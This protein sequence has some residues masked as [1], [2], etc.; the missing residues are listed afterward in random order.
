VSE[1]TLLRVG[2]ALT[3][4]GE[5]PIEDAGILIDGD[6]IASIGPF[7]EVRRAY[8][9]VSDRDARGLVAIPGLIDAHSHGRAIPLAEQGVREGPLEL[10]LAQLTALTPLDPHD[11]AFVAGSDLVAAG[12]TAVQVFFHTIDQDAEAYRRSASAVAE[13][14]AASGIEFELVLGFTD[15]DEFLPASVTD[16]PPGAETLA[17]PQRGL[18]AGEF[19]ALYDAFDRSVTL[20]PVAP[21]WCS[22]RA[23]AGIASRARA[24][25]RVHT[26]LLESRAQR[27][28]GPVERLREYGVLGDR[29]SAAHAVWLSQDEIAECAAAGTVL[30]HCPGSNRKL[31]G[32][33]APVGQWL[34]AGATAALG[35]DSHPCAD[36]PDAFDELRL[37]REMAG[38]RLGVQDAFALATVGGAAALGRPELGRLALGAAASLVLVSVPDAGADAL[39]A[40]LDG[41]SRH[42]VVEVWVRGRLLV[43]DG[44]LRG[45]RDVEAARARLRKELAADAGPRRRRLAAIAALEPWLEQT[46]SL[47]ETTEVMH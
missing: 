18:D 37:A 42:D 47:Q 1:R 28:T 23:W 36:P 38:G 35:L 32:A 10:F 44:R 14:L 5:G 6:S 34:D 46:W 8:P 17:R 21:Q 4:A 3:A 45:R 11:D 22:D 25:A 40:L 39:E 7:G 29:L 12:V 2:H 9:L 41:A 33:T 26:H 20:G 27:G 43:E 19:L 15:Q 30:V 24:G 31:A 13:G 16:V